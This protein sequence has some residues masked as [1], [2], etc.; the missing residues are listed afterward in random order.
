VKRDDHAR[1]L[2]QALLDAL[3]ALP[4]SNDGPP[5]WVALDAE[6]KRRGKSTRQLRA[7]CCSHGVEIR[8]ENH[9]DAWVR[10]A[11]VDRAVAGM[12]VASSPTRGDEIDQELHKL[13]PAGSPQP[14]PSRRART[15]ST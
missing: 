5:E 3:R 4:Q 13:W 9:R 11:D 2:G 6:A 1:H 10:P 12:P 14:L 7:W 8:Q 15:R